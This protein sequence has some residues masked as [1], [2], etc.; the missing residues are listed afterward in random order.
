MHPQSHGLVE[1]CNQTIQKTLVKLAEE[2]PSEWD[3]LLT[4]TLF[5]LRQ[6]PNASTGFPPFG[7][8][9]RGPIDIKADS[10]SDRNEENDELIHAYSYA[11]KLKAIIK[12]IK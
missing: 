1:R 3:T 2:N 4:P 8:K 5:A 11:L 7:R 9:A 10:C 6:M 12:K